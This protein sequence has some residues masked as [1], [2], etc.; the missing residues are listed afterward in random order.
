MPTLLMSAMEA[1]AGWGRGSRRLLGAEVQPEVA[2][3][4]VD[5]QVD[6]EG[7]AEGQQ[8]IGVDLESGRRR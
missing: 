7:V 4:A 2:V 1:P 6:E 8:W 3:A 5:P